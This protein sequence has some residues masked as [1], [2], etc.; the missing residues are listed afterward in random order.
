MESVKEDYVDGRAQHKRENNMRNRIPK[1]HVSSSRSEK[2]THA[3]DADINF[4]N[5]K[6]PLLC[7]MIVL[8]DTTLMTTTSVQSE[9][10]YD[11]HMLEKVDRNIIP[12]STNMCHRGGEIEQNAEKC[13]VSCPLLDLSFDNMTTEFSNQ[14]SESEK[15]FSHKDRCPLQ[16]DFSDC[17]FD[18]P[19]GKDSS[20]FAEESD[21]SETKG[22]R[23]L[24]PAPQRKEEYTLQCALIFKEE[25]L[26]KVKATL[27]S[28]WTEKDQ[29]NNLLK[30]SRLMRS[31]EKFVGGKLFEGDLRLRQK[32]HMILSYD[33][34]INQNFR[35]IENNADTNESNI[36][37][38]D[39]HGSEGFSNQSWANDKAI[40]RPPA[41]LLTVLCRSVKVLKLKNI[42]KDATLKLFKNGMSMSVQKSQVHKMAKLQD[43]VEIVL[44]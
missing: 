22:S 26:L 35:D 5:D 17:T 37:S 36:L 8:H 13:Q 25:N 14:L 31:L 16:K 12:D 1:R 33:V 40:I 34:L 7:T 3:E 19:E 39:P 24:R 42:K 6:Q 44:G 43:G 32:N 23:N 41:F 20:L 15:N 28:A 38:V 2:D 4:V 11:T 29:I 27:K 30:E 18:N 21:I 9:P 10:I